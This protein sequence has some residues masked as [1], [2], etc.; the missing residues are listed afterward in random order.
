M[1]HAHGSTNDENPIHFIAGIPA[2]SRQGSLACGCGRDVGASPLFPLEWRNAEEAQEAL[3]HLVRRDPHQFGGERSRWTLAHLLACC[4]GLRLHSR[5][6]L[7]R[8][9]RR[10]GIHYKRGRSSIHSPDP[11]YDEKVARIK[12]LQQ[13]VQAHPKE[14]LLYEDVCT[15]YRQPS[16]AQAYTRRVVIA[17]TPAKAPGS[18][19]ACVWWRPWTLSVGASSSSGGA[20]SAPNN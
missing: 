13:R 17:R 20:R 2:T 1:W 5:S 12:A 15:L 10:L 4:H 14:V 8:L 3:L 16:M 9:L 19:S 7:W 6:G 18:N 11:A